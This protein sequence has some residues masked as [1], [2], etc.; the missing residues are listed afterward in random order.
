MIRLVD[1][2]LSLLGILFLSPIMFLLLIAGLFDIGSPLFLS[3][4]LEGIK[5]YLH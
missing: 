4:E 2:L 3:L 1:F 5:S